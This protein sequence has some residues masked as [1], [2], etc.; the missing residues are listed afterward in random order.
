MGHD[1]ASLGSADGAAEV[2]RLCLEGQL[3]L[4]RALEVENQLFRDEVDRLRGSR[5]RTPLVGD[6]ID[7][8]PL[9]QRSLAE[10]LGGAERWLSLYSTVD[11]RGQ[12]RLAGASAAL[13]PTVAI[14]PVDIHPRFLPL[15]N[16]FQR[17]GTGG[18]MFSKPEDW[19]DAIHQNP[20][21]RPRGIRRW[22]AQPVNLDDLHV[23]VQIGR[24]IYGGNR[25]PGRHDPVDNQRPWRMIE[26]AFFRA[27]VIVVLQPDVFIKIQDQLTPSQRTLIQQPFLANV[28]DPTQLELRDVVQHMVQSGATEAWIRLDTVIGF[29]KSYLRDWA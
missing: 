24:M 26:A 8:V 23:Y 3:W 2:L 29:A 1:Q 7:S 6:R 16:H 22:G 25:P 13:P 12:A 20:S 4:S 9:R 21:M 27:M 14:L 19:P 5:T 18:P 10:R 28:D 11:G 17:G 15:G